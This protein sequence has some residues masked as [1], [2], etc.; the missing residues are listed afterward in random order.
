[1]K[2]RLWN[3]RQ[4]RFGTIP[5]IV[6]TTSSSSSLPY[7]RINSNEPAVLPAVSAVVHNRLHV[8]RDFIH[9]QERRE[10]Q[11]IR[12]RGTELTPFAEISCY[13]CRRAREWHL[14]LIS[15]HHT[16]Y[17][18]R[19]KL[20]FAHIPSDLP[21]LRFRRIKSASAHSRKRVNDAGCCQV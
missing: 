13:N 9:E 18:L 11:A 14:A 15:H 2:Q 1:M 10:A 17:T 20:P 4:L 6:K 16:Y 12:R 5:S 3:T 7:R 19:S 21:T 8:M